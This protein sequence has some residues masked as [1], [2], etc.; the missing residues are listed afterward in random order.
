MAA[1]GV[2]QK[3]IA[4]IMDTTGETLRLKFR[5]EL[6]L[7][8]AKAN[9]K[10]ADTLFKK[11]IGGDTAALIFWLK[12]RCNWSEKQRL[13]HDGAVTIRVEFDND[14]APAP[15]PGASSD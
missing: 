2:P 6:D 15:S 1:Y 11:A 4:R 13:E 7:G 8:M 12:A 14:Q 10:V 3:I 9:V 5:D